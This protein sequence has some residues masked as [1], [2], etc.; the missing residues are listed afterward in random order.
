VNAR[1]CAT[2]DA[3]ETVAQLCLEATHA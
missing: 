3:T 2:T 1:A